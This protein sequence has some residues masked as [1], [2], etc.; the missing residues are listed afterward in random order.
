MPIDSTTLLCIDD[1]PQ[2]LETPQSDSGISGILRQTCVEKVC[3]G[4]DVGGRL[5]YKPEG[6]DAEAIACH[7]KHRFPICR[8]SCSRP[9]QRSRSESCGW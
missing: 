4:K 1:R 2:M 6:M 5:E 7:I 9:T 8:S 3:C